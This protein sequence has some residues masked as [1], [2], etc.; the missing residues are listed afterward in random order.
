MRKTSP[1]PVSLMD[2]AWGLLNRRGVSVKSCLDR[3]MSTSQSGGNA[4][5]PTGPYARLRHPQY[6]GSVMMLLGFRCGGRSLRTCSY[7][8]IRLVTVYVG[9]LHSG[10]TRKRW[11]SLARR[12]PVMLR[13]RQRS[14]HTLAV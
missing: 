8:T 3:P 6:D 14:F 7:S 13:P 5:Q 12:M 9:L 10:G 1:E 2:M 4:V 11:P